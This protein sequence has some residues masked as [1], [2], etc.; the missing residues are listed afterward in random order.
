MRT[1]V[2]LVTMMNNLLVPMSARIPATQAANLIA[3]WKLGETSGTAADDSSATGADGAYAG[4]YTLGQTGIGD[5]SLSTL[6]AGGRVSLAANLAA[7]DA[8]FLGSAGTL[9]VWAKVSAA[10]VWTDGVTR[11]IVEIG[12]DANNRILLYKNNSSNIV[13]VLY[14]AGGTSQN[15]VKT[16]FNTTG[17]FSLIATWDKAADQVKAYVNGVQSDTTKTGLGVWAGS[18]ASTWS[19]IADVSSA[20]SANNFTGN[21]SQVAAWKVA[22]TAAEVAGIGIL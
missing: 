17:W 13:S 21:I 9:A 20:G 22:L 11:S 4:T 6:F 7:L 15:P 12:V 10:G 5:G 3:Y 14:V 1:A 2:K 8:V 16:S 19:A 18:L